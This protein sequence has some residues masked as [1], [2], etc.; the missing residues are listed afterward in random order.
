M[1]HL[2]LH[3]E[4]NNFQRNE[5]R[6][7]NKNNKMFYS[8]SLHLFSLWGDAEQVYCSEVSQAVSGRHSRTDRLKKDKLL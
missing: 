3:E 4:F 6:K 7:M 1:I 5:A 2:S 8:E